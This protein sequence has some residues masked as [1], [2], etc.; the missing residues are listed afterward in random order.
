[1]R[2]FSKTYMADSNDLSAED[3][4]D[5]PEH[6]EDDSIMSTA[7]DTQYVDARLEAVEARMDGRVAAIQATISGFIGLQDE[8]YAQI[9]DHF[10]RLERLIVGN[11]NE[12]K[13]LKR[14]FKDLQN[15]FKNL[16][17][18]I[19]I[20]AITAVLATVF[21]IGTLNAMVLSN[22]LAAFESGKNTAAAQAEVIKQ[23]QELTIIAR[24]LHGELA[25]PGGA[26]TPPAPASAPP[27]AH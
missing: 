15:D 9:D 25:N 21:G 5:N 18:T 12:I 10:V 26:R 24:Q 27:S 1:M 2:I 19:I 8:R 22:M 23:A 3:S 6:E 16:K 4:I 11:Q 13:N 14:D 17:S 20:T 7:T